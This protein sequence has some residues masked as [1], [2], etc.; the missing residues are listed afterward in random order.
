MT[1]RHAPY[2]AKVINGK[3]CLIKGIIVTKKC[4]YCGHHEIG[5]TD[6]SGEYFPL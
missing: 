1:E 2:N 4:D 6:N 5:I 3:K